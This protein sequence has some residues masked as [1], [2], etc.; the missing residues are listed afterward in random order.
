VSL[1]RYE[2]IFIRL[3]AARIADGYEPQAADSSELRGLIETLE[4]HFKARDL[5]MLEVI[6]DAPALLK[7]QAE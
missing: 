4:A 6:G 3:V 5:R 2:E 7:R 1:S